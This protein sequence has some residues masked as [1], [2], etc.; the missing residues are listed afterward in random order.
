MACDHIAAEFVVERYVSGTLPESDVEAFEAHMLTCESCQTKVELGVG[1]REGLRDLPPEAAGRGPSSLIERGPR[2]RLAVA[3]TI[4]LA[5]L[6]AGWWLVAGSGGRH[7]TRRVMLMP[8][9]KLADDGANVGALDALYARIVGE[10]VEVGS[11]RPLAAPSP[12]YI[13]RR[14]GLLPELAREAGA[15]FVLEAAISRAGDSLSLNLQLR[16]ANNWRIA[17]SGAFAAPAD[18]TEALYGR[19]DE[20]GEA[21]M[22][23]SGIEVSREERGELVRNRDLDPRARRLFDE[24]LF[25][26]RYGDPSGVPR[27]LEALQQAVRIEPEF[28]EAHSVLATGY[29]TAMYTIALPTSEGYPS[30][31]EAARTAIAIDETVGDAHSALGWSLFMY[32]WEWDAALREL[33]RGYTLEPDD[34]LAAFFY[35]FVLSMMGRHEAAIRV[36]EAAAAADPFS[37]PLA[38]HVG[39]VHS[40]ARNYE[41]AIAGYERALEL[42]PG[43]HFAY[44]RLPLAYSELGRHERAIEVARAAVAQDPVYRVHLG[45]ALAQAGRSEEARPIAETLYAEVER[46]EYPFV[47]ILAGLYGMLGETDRAFELLERAAAERD[48]SL[49]TIHESSEYD[50]LRS[51]PRFRGLQERLG[52]PAE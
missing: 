12:Q 37:L 21:L 14:A 30:A 51:D 49:Q 50:S 10:L 38:N 46:G 33:E 9:Q 6:G 7:D 45:M 4:L 19:A 20:I 27:A 26:L 8:V 34:E 40:Y 2:P 47:T 18:S 15:D 1:I 44:Q 3:A 32:E 28:A 43:W 29:I 39:T 16:E 22:E 11:V 35:S 42:Q 25:L 17:W 31:I 23:Q 13:E 5:A 36:A 24:G 52:Y 41:R 48:P